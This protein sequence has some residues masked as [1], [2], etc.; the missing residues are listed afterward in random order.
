M[1]ELEAE[2][3]VEVEFALELDTTLE[4]KLLLAED[5]GVSLTN[6]LA[7]FELALG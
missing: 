4:A 3:A 6:G 5:G 1:F 2:V 7:A